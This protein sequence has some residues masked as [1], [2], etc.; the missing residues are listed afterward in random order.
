MEFNRALSKILRRRRH[1]LE[2]SQ[3][4][5]AEAA[6]CERSFIAKIETGR[7]GIGLEALLGLCRGLQMN[8]SDF[9][10]ELEQELANDHEESS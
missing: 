1:L 3:E 10:R 9:V 6:G 5:L 2:F 7:S 8:A 4:E